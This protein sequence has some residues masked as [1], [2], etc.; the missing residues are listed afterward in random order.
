MVPPMRDCV[1]ADGRFLRS[2]RTIVA[3]RLARRDSP[4]TIGSCVVDAGWENADPASIA[5]ER[6]INNMAFPETR[7][8]RATDWRSDAM[9]KTNLNVFVYLAEVVDHRG[10]RRS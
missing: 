8:Q 2:R 6:N 1:R 10:S 3:L 7:A 5:R 4:R 9:M